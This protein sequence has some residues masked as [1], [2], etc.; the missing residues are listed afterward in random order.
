MVSVDTPIFFPMV[1]FVGYFC[2]YFVRR[3]LQQ[4]PFSRA[5]RSS[6]CMFSTRFSS[7]ICSSV[8][9]RMMAGIFC[10]PACWLAR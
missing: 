10:S 7:I 1:S 9:L 4:F 6:R 8:K 2:G 5:L 3:C